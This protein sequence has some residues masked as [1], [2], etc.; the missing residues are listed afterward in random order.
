M[1]ASPHAALLDAPARNG[2][3][4]PPSTLTA[5][6]PAGP[7][8]RSAPT[9][10]ST[11]T[12]EHGVLSRPRAWASHG[13]LLAVATAHLAAAEAALA[14][15]WVDRDQAYA[16]L[17]AYRELL[18]ALSAHAQHLFGRQRIENVRRAV[19]PDPSDAAAVTLL[20]AFRAVV[21]RRPCPIGGH[22]APNGTA[23][24]DWLHAAR[25]VRAA[26]D[27]PATHR[28][29]STGAWRTPISHRL[30]D[31]PVRRAGCGGW[32]R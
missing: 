25:A 32:S 14:T 8:P 22:C 10:R 17:L 9:R 23:A 20:D 27:L 29:P 16:E 12:A 21:H 4:A 6:E 30:D 28:D 2:S 19:A 18:H 5:P 31:Q 3:P 11:D 24:P 7:I 13:D 26:T 1:P 15:G